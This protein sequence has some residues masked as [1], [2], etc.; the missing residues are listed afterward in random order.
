[1][2][3]LGAAEFL[4]LFRR[5]AISAEGHVNDLL[6]RISENQELNVFTWFA[7]SQVLEAARAA[8]ARRARGEPLGRLAGLPLIVKD[9]INT[10][11]FPTSAGTRALK[12][13]HPS[14]N[15]PVWQRLADEGALLLGK[16]NMHELAA[17]STSSNPVFGV[18]RNP[19]ARAHIPG[20]SSGGTAAAIAAGLAPAGLGTDTVGSVRAPSCFCGIAGLRP[21][22]A[23]TRAY[24]PEGVVP[25][26]RLFDTIG[27]MAASVADLVPLHE[28]ITGATV[29]SLAPAGLRIGLSMEPFWT[30]L[31]PQVERVV[32]AARDQLAAAGMRFVPLDLGDL[33]ARATALHGKIL[34]V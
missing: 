33:V 13:F 14:V 18:V 12:A 7:P 6:G 3:V 24:S 22:T 23:E 5:G 20:G 30:D 4:G 2:T 10:V 11:G 9:N 31:D 8:D 27:P 1:M 34:G 26:T 15:A 28:V 19:H 32:R 25:L 21:T 17:G 29:P 16:A